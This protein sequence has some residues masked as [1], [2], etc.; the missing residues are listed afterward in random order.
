MPDATLC[1]TEHGNVAIFVD[2][3]ALACALADQF[4]DTA[5][6]AIAQRGRFVVALAGGS[7]PKA[8][9]DLL[10]LSPR[11]FA[12]DW[13]KIIVFFG[14]ERCVPPTSDQ[15]NFRM[16]Q[17]S[18]LAQVPLPQHAIHRMLG[19]GNPAQAAEA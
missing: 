5:K 13:E 9:Y 3:P 8:A 6:E 16:A 2:P 12:I 10:A 11:K 18:F 15:S 14:D 17:E 4:I 19:E 7:T 1:Q